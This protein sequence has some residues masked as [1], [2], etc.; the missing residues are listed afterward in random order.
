LVEIGRLRYTNEKNRVIFREK[1]LLTMLDYVE[2]LLTKTK[3]RPIEGRVPKPRGRPKKQKAATLT[4]MPSTTVAA[5]AGPS[6]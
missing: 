1:M 5:Q 2:M 4:P 3:R 6:T